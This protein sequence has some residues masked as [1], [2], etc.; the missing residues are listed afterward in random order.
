M[1]HI[2]D[3]LHAAR[4]EARLPSRRVARARRAVAAVAHPRRARRHEALE[5]GK[6]VTDKAVVFLFLH[7]GPSQFET[8]DP[9]MT[10]PG[11]D[12]QPRPAR[13]RPRFPASPSAPVPQARRAGR[14]AV[15]RAVVRPRRRQPRHQD[16][17]RQGHARANL[18]SLYAHV[19]GG[20]HPRHGHADQ[21]ACSRGRSIRTPGAARR[22]RQVRPHRPVPRATT[23]VPAGGNGDS[24]RT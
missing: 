19:A 5:A 17:R 7:G 21:R 15:R 24:R 16:D 4:S 20:N 18:G 3:S 23:P 10:A 13:S 1:L 9:K 6:P 12:P 14:P 8:F 22:L 11:R 2:G